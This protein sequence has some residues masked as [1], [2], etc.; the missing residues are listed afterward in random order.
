M[1][2]TN[3]TPTGLLGRLVRGLAAAAVL[4]VLV[5]G[6]PAGLWVFVGWPLP[7]ALPD[8]AE[9][10]RALTGAA[11]DDQV[12]INIIALGCWTV[13]G[14]F[15]A[16]VAMETVAAVRGRSARR[17]PLAG[18][19]QTAA[20][21]LVAAVLLALLPLAS[22]IPSSW[23]DIYRLNNGKP[24]PDGRAL[25]DTDPHHIRIWPGWILDLPPGTPRSSAPPAGQQPSAPHPARQGPPSP[26]TEPENSPAPAPSSVPSATPAPASTADDHADGGHPVPSQPSSPVVELPSGAVVGLSLAAAITLALAAARLHRRRRRLLGEP[27]PGIS[28]S[29]PLVTPTV[30]RLRRAVHA[31]SRTDGDDRSSDHVAGQAEPAALRSGAASDPGVVAIGQRGGREVCF[32]LSKG[33]LALT[34]PTALDAARSIVL[35]L[36]ARTQL[37]SDTA[38]VGVLLVGDPLAERLFGH[39]VEIPGLSVVPDLDTA[40]SAL[41]VEQAHRLRLLQDHDAA[42]VASYLH[43]DPAEP[44]PTLVL[45]VDLN[46]DGRGW[47]QRLAAVLAVGHRLAIGALLLGPAGAV[48]P[49]LVLGADATIRAVQPDGSLPDLAGTFAFTLGPDDTAEL[50]PVLAALGTRPSR[51]QAPEP[52]HTDPPADPPVAVGEVEVAPTSQVAADR[53]PIRVRCFGPLR[54][55]LDGAEVRT[56]LRTKARELLAFLLL[57]PAGVGREVAIEALWPEMDPARGAERAKDAL[58]SLRQALRAATG[59]SGATVVELVSDRWHVNPDLVDCDV[60][61]FQAALAAAAAAA[62]DQAKLDALTRAAAAYAD[63]LLQDGGYEWVEEPREEL[64]RQAA[65]VA[66]RLAELRERAGDLDGALAALED[67]ARWDAYNEELYQ[68]IMRLQARMGRLD[69]VR[70]TYTRLRDRLAELGVDPDETTE[71]L[72]GELRRSGMAGPDSVGSA[73]R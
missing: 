29:D 42:D 51:P 41:E 37:Q 16:A 60:W 71:Q 44:L 56:G 28:H 8:L 4:L 5:A 21:S 3:A 46:R 20:G 10:G 13:W 23:R 52:P 7:H 72:L 17:V 11:I 18:P 63:T 66:G 1:T 54:I 64:R 69:A 2:A 14:V 31:S 67:G 49:T 62:D 12:L 24:Q 26:P 47:E 50:L 45:V 25:T 39:P 30:R 58:K 59:Q 6:V 57:H 55:E 38:E 34:G 9:L 43:A 32:D 35:S 65:D 36:L 15:T 19:L 40:L 33:G 73:D 48:A 61:H 53:R 27:G 22:R 68:R 70:R